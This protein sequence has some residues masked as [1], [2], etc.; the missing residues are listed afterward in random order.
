MPPAERVTDGGSLGPPHGNSQEDA[1]WHA[2]NLRLLLPPSAQ[3]RVPS[4]LDI[5]FLVQGQIMQLLAPHRK[6]FAGTA[7]GL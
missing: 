4:P 6:E 3:A 2:R 1:H 7:T 5:A